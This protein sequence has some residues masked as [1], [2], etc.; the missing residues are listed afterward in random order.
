[1]VTAGVYIAVTVVL[2]SLWRAAAGANG[3]AVVGYT[4]VALSWYAAAAEVVTISLPSRV[5][6][7]TGDDIATGAVAVEM[8]RPASVVGIRI[9]SQIGGALPRLGLCVALGSVISIAVAGAPPQLG[10]ALLAL[11]ALVLAIA[12]NLAAQHAFAAVSFWIRD[13]KST[14]FIYQK[15]VFVVG[16][17]LIPLEVLPGPVTTVAKLLPSMAMAYAPARLAAGFF[18]PW[19]LAVQMGWLVVLVVLAVRVFASGERRLQ[20]VGG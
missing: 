1:V 19:L 8:L 5:I 9:A 17:M 6:E 16:G 10:A 11:P 14:W 20:V 15:L 12:C 2:G 13:A 7:E 18:E 4:A 3:G